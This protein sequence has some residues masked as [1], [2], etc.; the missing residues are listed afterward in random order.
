MKKTILTWNELESEKPTHEDIYFVIV[1]ISERKYYNRYFCSVQVAEWVEQGSPIISRSKVTPCPKAGFYTIL[2]NSE[3]KMEYHY[4]EYPYISWAE[5]PKL[6][7]IYIHPYQHYQ[8]KKIK[9]NTKISAL[10]HELA[11]KYQKNQEYEFVG[12]KVTPSDAEFKMG[13][14]LIENLLS[15]LQKLKRE[16]EGTSDR[17]TL[18]KYIKK[19]EGLTDI[20]DLNMRLSLFLL[21]T[22]TLQNDKAYQYERY[23][24]FLSSAEI[25]KGYPD[26]LREVIA[27]HYMLA[28]ISLKRLLRFKEL[29][30]PN[31]M[32]EN[33]KMLLFEALAPLF[34]K[35]TGPGKDFEK[36]YGVS[37]EECAANQNFGCVEIQ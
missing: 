30:A 13:A 16:K 36:Q 18:T 19:T 2:E 32:I 4:L 17:E 28:T 11:E 15:I 33:D 5:I 24:K 14:I 34:M 8:G 27:K 3:G 23:Y 35:I 22:L 21:I 20:I 29:S 12:L 25:Y 9:L 31:I 1:P 10:Y 37:W 6:P 26:A 7:D